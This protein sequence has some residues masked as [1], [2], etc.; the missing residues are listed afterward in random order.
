MVDED[1]VPINAINRV[2]HAQLLEANG[3]QLYVTGG[4]SFV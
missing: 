4:H 2:L 3:A 1:A